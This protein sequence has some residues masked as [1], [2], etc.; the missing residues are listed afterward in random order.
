M[1]PKS[2]FSFFEVVLQQ[3]FPCRR[4]SIV[5]PTRKNISRQ[6]PE[7]T[8]LHGRNIMIERY[9]AIHKLPDAPGQP[10]KDL[11]YKIIYAIAGAAAKAGDPSPGL[12]HIARTLNLFEWAGIPRE[13]I[14]L[15]AAVYGDATP[16]VLSDG[17][18]KMRF[19]R[20]NPN[21]DLIN[22]L[23]ANGL[24][25]LVCGQSFLNAGF[26]PDE[27]DPAVILS[28][29]ALT[30]IPNFELKGYARMMY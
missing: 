3:I 29:S 2:E 17:A 7:S 11:D 16:V 20:H 12:L 14:H 24:E 26:H 23:V 27:L 30:V 9:G 6:V 28:L 8:T 1:I 4:V 25:I 13:H 5:L 19:N 15:K 22:Q 10:E 18:F 21:S